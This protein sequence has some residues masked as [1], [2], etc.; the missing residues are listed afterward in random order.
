MASY[1]IDA[2]QWGAYEKSLSAAAVDTV[3]FTGRDLK[4]VEVTNHDGTAPIYATTDA[5]TPTD[6]AAG[7]RWMI[8][9]GQAAQ[10]PPKSSGTTVVK[11]F[12]RAAVTYS[13]ADVS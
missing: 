13:V 6:K 7:V 8:P 2:G 12:C 1:T 3:T 9:P 5:T 10:F 11:V 4:L